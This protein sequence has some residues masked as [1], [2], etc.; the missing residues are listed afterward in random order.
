MR[1]V[2]CTWSG[3]CLVAQSCST[4][5][6]PHGLQLVRLL[7]SWN[8]PGKNTGMGSH[9]LLQGSSRPRDQTHVSCVAGRFLTTEPS[10]SPCLVYFGAKISDVAQLSVQL[11][12]F[13]D[14][15]LVSQL[16][17][18]TQSSFQSQKVGAS[19]FCSGV[20]PDS[21]NTSVEP[22]S[23][24]GV[25][26]STRPL[27][28]ERSAHRWAAGQPLSEDGRWLRLPLPGAALSSPGAE[29]CLQPVLILL[30]DLP[31][32]PAALQQCAEDRQICPSLAG[33]QFTKW[34]SEAHNEVGSISGLLRALGISPAARGFSDMP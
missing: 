5:L 23:G 27:L 32:L 3:C 8:S 13:K 16:Q 11:V 7:C 19:G 21:W 25:C 20:F 1:W 10:G 15:F 4:P 30:C 6:G 2:I 33:F 17:H 31:V 29:A 28:G 12:R 9:S 18:G 14:G 24:T 26:L 22:T 34:D